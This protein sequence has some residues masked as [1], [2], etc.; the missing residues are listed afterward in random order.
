M[1]RMEVNPGNP[2]NIGAIMAII[3]SIMNLVLMIMV[4]KMVFSMLREV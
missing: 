4:L 3:P 2:I 1:D